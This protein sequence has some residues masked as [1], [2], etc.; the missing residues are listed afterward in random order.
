MQTVTQRHVI[1]FTKG[2]S[3][4][5]QFVPVAE[6]RNATDSLFNLA[7]VH[8]CSCASDSERRSWRSGAQRR[9]AE[10]ENLAC[11]RA[12]EHDR[13]CFNQAC[14]RL[15]ERIERVDEQGKMQLST[16]VVADR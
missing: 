9:L 16:L 15:R 5:T 6:Y 8:F 1:P 14:Q 12:N 13:Y 11:K 3:P 4:L 2:L 7:N 10:L